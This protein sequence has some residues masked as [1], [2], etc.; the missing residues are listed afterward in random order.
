MN[1]KIKLGLLFGFLAFL[2]VVSASL[3]YLLVKQIDND[4]PVVVSCKAGQGR[5]GTVLAC[6]LV[7]TG[8]GAKD[9]IERVRSL[10]SGSIQSPHQ[11]DFV[12]MYEERLKGA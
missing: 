7:H 11:Q 10:R 5:T 1:L 12:Y 8:Y 4:V 2:L 9:A 3:S 6:Y